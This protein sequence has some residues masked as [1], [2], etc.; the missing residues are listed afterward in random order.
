MTS[1]MVEFKDCVNQVEIEDI[2]SNGLF[3]TRTKNLHKVRKG[4]YAGVLKKLNRTMG[5][6]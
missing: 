3:Y 2:A 5:N 4:D 1:D 6:E